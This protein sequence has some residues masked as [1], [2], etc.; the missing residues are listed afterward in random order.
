MIQLLTHFIL[1]IRIRIGESL[2]YRSK[3]G[4][5]VLAAIVGV[6][7]GAASALFREANIGL[8][9][10]L[11]GSTDDIVAI[12]ENLS[13]EM[14]LLIP[15][16]GGVLGGI[17]LVLGS[18][19][20]KGMRSQEYLEVIRLGDGVISIRPTLARLLSSL[21][22]ISS[23]ASIGREGGMVQLVALVS[24]SVGRFFNL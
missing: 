22:A 4:M 5:L 8:K 23:G 20:F 9:W 10:L 11:T 14:R 7:G 21:F 18:R 12:A 19:L 16:L 17:M 15:T 1:L 24:S 3:D 6:L 2:G 13:P